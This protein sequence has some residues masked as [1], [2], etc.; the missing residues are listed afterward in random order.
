MPLEPDPQLAAKALVRMLLTEG[1]DVGFD[2]ALQS[3]GLS[4]VGAGAGGAAPA[5]GGAAAAVGAWP[6]GKKRSEG[7]STQ[8]SSSRPS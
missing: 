6:L 7:M 2:L 1:D 4:L 3:V 5:G 8:P